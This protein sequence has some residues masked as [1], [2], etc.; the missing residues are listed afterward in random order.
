MAEVTVRRVREVVG[1]RK[2]G[3]TFLVDRL[4]PRGVKKSDLALDGWLK[5]VAPSTELRTWFA[6]DPDKWAEFRRR[7]RAELDADAEAAKP[8]LA[9]AADGPVTL[10]YDAHDTEH[11]QAVVLRAWLLDQLSQQP[12]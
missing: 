7:Y 3:P 10:L 9:A 8:L 5:E 2:Q 12:A 4:W 1:K 11:N 6:H